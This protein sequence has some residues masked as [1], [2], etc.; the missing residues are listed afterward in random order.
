MFILTNDQIDQIIQGTYAR[1]DYTK[2]L[3]NIDISFNC[4]I[5]KW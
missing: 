5:L 3:M 4:F 2:E 1:L